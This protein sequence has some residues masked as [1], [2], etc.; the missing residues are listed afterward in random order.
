ML[1]RKALAQRIN[2][3]LRTLLDK[4]LHIERAVLFGSF[5]K[6]TPHE[7]SDIDLAVW[8]DEFAGVSLA[9]INLYVVELRDHA[10]I[11]VRPYRSGTT[12]NEDPF[13][14]EILKTGEEWPLPAKH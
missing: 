13:L 5:A 6:G 12:I 1:T 8:A 11:S 7:Y 2:S 10:K 3:F 14:E 9:D 4:G